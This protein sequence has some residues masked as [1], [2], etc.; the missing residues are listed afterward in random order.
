[1]HALK[2]C[3]YRLLIVPVDALIA[4]HYGVGGVIHAPLLFQNRQI[5]EM[6]RKLPGKVGIYII[7]C[8]FAA[9]AAN[10]PGRVHQHP[11]AIC[12]P[13]RV[14]TFSPDSA[15]ERKHSCCSGQTF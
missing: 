8:L 5:L 1:V 6:L 7:T 11:E 13:L 14:G 2:L 10:A 4:V 3:K 12:A 9:S 15:S